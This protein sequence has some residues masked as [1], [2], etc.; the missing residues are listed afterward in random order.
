M[1]E[2]QFD[3]ESHT[4]KLHAED[5]P[6]VT[7][8]IGTVVPPSEGLVRWKVRC[9][10]QGIDPEERRNAAAILGTQVHLAFADLA[11]GNEVDPF[12]YPE[13]ASGFITGCR[14]F[15]DT[16][17]PQFLA[18][19]RKTYSEEHWYA[20]TLDAHVAFTRG[21]FKG[22]T[23]RIDLKTGKRI[24]KES[25]FPQ[26]LAYEQ[27]DIERGYDPSDMRLILK[28]MP[29][30]NFSLVR[31]TDTFWDFKVLLDHYRSVKAREARAK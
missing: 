22:M 11:A 13:E 4:Y 21:A 17:G 6:N 18:S 19:E 27:A 10:H 23:A 16:H 31:V 5:I 26:L 2:L 8:I 20:G 1:T 9:A 7:T 15:I 3:A 29:T 14:R 30:G 25:H 28:V 12:D 24:Y